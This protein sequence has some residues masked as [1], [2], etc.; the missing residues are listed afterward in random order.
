MHPRM[1]AWPLTAQ[2]RFRMLHWR[3]RW[4]Y[5]PQIRMVELSAAIYLFVSEVV[6][7]AAPHKK[8]L[9][10]EAKEKERKHE[11]DRFHSVK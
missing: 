9:D 7:K 2:Q 10:Q 4:Q 11:F 1:M 5:H 8:S 3:F 6:F